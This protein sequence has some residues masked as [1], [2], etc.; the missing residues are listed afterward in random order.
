MYYY[1]VD[2]YTK[3]KYKHTVIVTVFILYILT[4]LVLYGVCG[5]FIAFTALAII[6][7]ADKYYLT[8]I[9]NSI[10]IDI[11]KYLEES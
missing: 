1:I 3:D 8:I 11:M 4:S 7:L 10:D 2:Y 6:S 9:R 5:I